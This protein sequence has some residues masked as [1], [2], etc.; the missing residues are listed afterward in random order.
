MDICIHKLFERQ[1]EQ[2]PNATAVIC[3][4]KT[5]TY[6]ELNQR[7]NRLAHF[8]M[9]MN[10]G[11]DSL[12]GICIE[13]SID[14]VVAIFGIL[15]A[16]GAYIPL[17]PEYPEER[18]S[19][20]LEDSKAPVL[21]T[22]EKL[23]GNLAQKVL[24]AI[25]LDTEWEKIAKESPDNPTGV[26][27]TTDNLIY[28]IYTSGS[29][30]KPKGSALYHRGF[31]NLLDWYSKEFQ[32]NKSSRVLLMTS[33]SFDLT[34][35]NIYAPLIT[36][37]KLV[38]LQTQHYDASIILE[39][40]SQHKITS[41]NCTPSSFYGLLGNSDLET[42]KT[43][44]SL[45]YVFLGGEPISIPVLKA[46]IESSFFNA[47]IVNTYGPTECTDVCVFHRIEEPLKY[48]NTSVPIGEPVY[49][50]E[51]YI[52]NEE[53]EMVPDGEK[54]ELCISGIGVGAGYL[55]RPDLTKDRFIE[56]PF[57]S[58]EKHY[59]YKTG[60]LARFLPN[61]NIEFLGRL[62]HQ[63]KIRGFRIEL[64]EIETQLAQHEDVHE[65]VV[66]THEDSPGDKQLVAYLVL[67][68]NAVPSVN[69]LRR[70]LQSSVPDYM[71]P[72]AW[73][74]LDQMPLNPNGKI[75]RHALPEP[76]RERPILEQEYIPPKS[77]IEKYLT[78]MWCE[79]LNIN[80]IGTQDR[81]FE[82]GG[83]SIKAIQFVGRLGREL[84]GTIPIIAFFQASSISE[85]SDVL[86]KEYAALVQNKFGNELSR[87]SNQ[88][89]AKDNVV[90]RPLRRAIA[91][92][93]L[94]IERHK[95]K[96]K[97]LSI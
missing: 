8:L 15:K 73:I 20:M 63:V 53:I 48:M 46:W 88:L 61:G 56:N 13:R 17:D 76:N 49:N 75:D 1:V 38:L 34:Q 93:R 89:S 80:R 79:I 74:F 67:K 35:K 52:L 23:I 64:G 40:I 97:K 62:D 31:S 72:T 7:A 82:L 33:L 18:L 27:V 94:L 19:Y 25:S 24:T 69:N 21:L 36:G 81:F 16:G 22:Q 70:F 43:L 6:I 91:N 28:V 55:H 29:T 60:D 86:Q 57:V 26:E 47:C 32:F 42:L 54:G 90:N 95:Q 59:L 77:A 65:T 66:A 11:A 14:M 58:G 10:V 87:S 96:S 78:N 39:L 37:G 92:R 68:P 50:T 45:H 84:G 71:L 4:N 41:V 85:I 2:T 12:V 3:D 51:L 5:I 30:G 9:K 83:S 44:S